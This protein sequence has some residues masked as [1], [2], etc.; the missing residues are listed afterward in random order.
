MRNHLILECDDRLYPASTIGAEFL[1]S[2]QSRSRTPCAIRR[3]VIDE[4]Y[5][6]FHDLIY[7]LQ[8]EFPEVRVF[9]SRRYM[10]DEKLCYAMKDRK[11][12]YTD[13]NHIGVIGSDYLGERFVS[14]IYN[15]GK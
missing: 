9:D 3:T 10:C 6:E 4:R 7:T 1:V 5:K 15:S 8:R 2:G 14:E 13:D 12:F 11:M